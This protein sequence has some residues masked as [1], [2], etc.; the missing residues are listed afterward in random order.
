MKYQ[1]TQQA[2]C[3]VLSNLIETI[4]DMIELKLNLTCRYYIR[5]AK[6]CLD[7]WID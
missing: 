1:K 7:P 2:R 3:M 6:V 5:V 4:V